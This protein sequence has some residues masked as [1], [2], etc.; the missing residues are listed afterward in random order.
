MILG[1]DCEKYVLLWE[2]VFVIFIVSNI[3][4]GGFIGYLG[5]RVIRLWYRSLVKLLLGGLRIVKCYL[6][7][8]FC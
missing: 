5:G 4:L 2:F 6:N 7:K 8:L 3:I 1:I